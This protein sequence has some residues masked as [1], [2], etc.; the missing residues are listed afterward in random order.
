MFNI[1]AISILINVTIKQLTRAQYDTMI[2]SF[3]LSRFAYTGNVI[4]S[5]PQQQQRRLVWKHFT[6]HYQGRLPLFDKLFVS[7]T[8][9]TYSMPLIELRWCGIFSHFSSSFRIRHIVPLHSAHSLDAFYFQIYRFYFIHSF[10]HS[11]MFFIHNIFHNFSPFLRPP[12]TRRLGSPNNRFHW[13][14]YR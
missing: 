14:K 2:T 12:H 3:F 8:M 11:Y 10:I 1:Y 9:A 7:L 13:Q 4:S 5:F 6:R